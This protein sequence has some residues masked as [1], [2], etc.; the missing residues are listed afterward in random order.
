MGDIKEFLRSTDLFGGLTD[1]ELDK[2]TRL[3]HERVYEAGATV[4][5]EGDVSKEIFL[6]EEGRVVTEVA[7]RLGSGSGRQGVM[8][9]M[10][11]GQ[12]FGLTPICNAEI[13]ITQASTA[14]ARCVEKTKVIVLNGGELCSFFEENTYTGYKVMQRLASIWRSRL[15][16]IGD[17][18]AHVLSITAHDLKSPLAAVESYHRV[19]LD[20]YAGEITEKQKNML[21]RSS[22]R[23]KGLLNLIDN[24]LDISRIDAREL[25]MGATSLLKVVEDTRGVI[26]PLAEE[27]GLKLEVEVPKDLP[28]ITGSPERLLQVFNNLLGNAVKFTPKGGTVTLKV[29]EAD[30]RI[31]AEVMD[32]GIGISPEE[33]PKIF[34]D[35]F[36]G[37]RVD[38]TG[39]GLGLGISKRIIEGHGG[40]IWVESPC[41]ESGVGSKFS[42]TLPKNL[43]TIRA[44]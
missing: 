40:S 34:T 29:S 25:K 6:V 31:L 19:M 3:C 9:V 24:I 10:T 44:E 22:E 37:I 21:L 16:R 28:L 17:M 30:D 38:S 26:E 11:K 23:I 36:R 39:A 20:G 5:R 8:A 7:L 2:I 13:C 32:T 41:P 35:F 18:T 15:Q 33:L 1:D 4:F 12:V 27:K 43:A 14:T 42:F